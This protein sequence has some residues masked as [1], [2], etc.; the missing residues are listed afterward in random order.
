[1]HAVQLDLTLEQLTLTNKYFN[2]DA[3]I[4]VRVSEIK[5]KEGNNAIVLNS[6]ARVRTSL[7]PN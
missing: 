4:L 2:E 3:V 1:M 7:P 6:F 5:K